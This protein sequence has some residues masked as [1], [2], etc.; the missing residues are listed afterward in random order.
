[1]THL[2]FD[3]HYAAE[4]NIRF[5]IEEIDRYLA[6]LPGP[7]IAEVREGIAI[8]RGQAF[9]PSAICPRSNKV[10]SDHLASALGSLSVTHPSLAVAIEAV[11]PILSWGTYDAYPPGDIGE[12][13]ADNHAFASV[14]GAATGL[15]SVDY[16]MGLFVIAPHFVYRDHRHPAPELYAPLTGPHGWRF[17]PD[18]ALVVT[19]AHQPVWNEP[20]RPHLTKVGPVPFL[21]IYAWTR[22]VSEPAQVLPASDWAQLE[23][24]RLDAG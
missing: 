10:V 17:Q 7:G 6:G 13:F 8:A 23:A 2:E 20:N 22:D 5:H 18:T 19:P 3:V 16:Y 24:L 1:M 11:A 15:P 14:I 9:A 4:R 21:S 12:G